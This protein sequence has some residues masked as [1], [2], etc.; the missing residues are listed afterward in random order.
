MGNDADVRDRVGA[1][2]MPDRGCLGLSVPVRAALRGAAR[3]IGARDAALL[4]GWVLGIPR[5][6]LYIAPDRPLAR[7]EFL[8][9]ERLVRRRRRGEPLAYLTGWVRFFTVDLEVSDDVLIPRPETEGLVEA[10]ITEVAAQGATWAGGVPVRMADI[11]TGS[12]AIAI[13]VASELG[14]RVQ[15]HATD[16]SPAALAI[17]R[18]NVERLGLRG[19][20][21]LHGPGDLARPL[22][23]DGIQ[24]DVLVMNPPYVRRRDLG[25]LSREVAREPRLALDGGVDGLA[26]IRRL[27][28]EIPR[29]GT[30]RGGGSLWL[31]IGAGQAKEVRNL[32]EKHGFDDVRTFP[33]LGGIER[34]VSARWPGSRS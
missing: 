34:V 24:V 21:F 8:R 26:V 17:A 23:E 30:L 6:A 32:L 7:A 29:Q 27:I 1:E 5:E 9:F 18:R 3:R 10:V 12:G 4:L 19:R 31:E 20:V 13:S 22:T 2:A 25:R 28:R 15:V 33:D 14:E 16:R 11:G